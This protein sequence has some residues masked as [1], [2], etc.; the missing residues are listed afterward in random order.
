MVDVG[1]GGAGPGCGAE[2]G[3]GTAGSRRGAPEAGGRKIKLVVQYD[4]TDFCGYQRQRGRRTVQGELEAALARVAGAR[5]V[6][7]AAGRTDAG[8]HARGQVVSFRLPP[9]SRIPTGRLAVALNSVLP[10]DLAAVTA[11]EVEPGFCALRSARAKAYS[12]T[13]VTSPHPSP[14][15]RRFALHW[16]GPLDLAR[17]EEAMRRFLGCHDFRAFRAEGSSARTTRRT[18]LCFR[19]EQEED[20]LRFWVEADGFLYRM[21][22]TMVGTVLEVGRGR[23]E[24]GQVDLA[25]ATGDKGLAGPALPAHGLCLERVYYC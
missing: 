13:L 7:R 19:L 20:R 8:V 10:P 5:V 6:V 1:G 2:P 22:R 14:F 9:Q 16:P 11:E 4:G 17:A 21:V 3:R 18:V 24:P 12:Y 15:W 25:L 23:F